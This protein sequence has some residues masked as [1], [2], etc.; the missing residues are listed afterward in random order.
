MGELVQKD[1]LA[2]AM[3]KALRPKQWT[4]NVLLFAALV[5]STR[6]LDTTSTLRALWGFGA[7]CLVSSI[8]YIIN[9]I[10]DRE[11]D[12]QHP[13]SAC[14]PSPPGP[15]PSASPGRKRRGSLSWVSVSPGCWIRSSRLSA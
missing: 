3:L 13:A 7:F 2:L 6:F 12:V 4:K 9:D 8:G 5:F 11:A 10:L 1:A 15:C 14:G